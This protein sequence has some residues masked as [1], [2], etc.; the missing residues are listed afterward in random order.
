MLLPLPGQLGEMAD[1]SANDLRSRKQCLYYLPIAVKNAIELGRDDTFSMIMG[2][3]ASK[4]LSDGMVAMLFNFAASLDGEMRG[5]H[6]LDE[7]D[8]SLLFSYMI[9]TISDEMARFDGRSAQQGA[10]HGRSDARERMKELSGRLRSKE[11]PK[12]P[13]PGCKKGFSA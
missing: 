1:S 5:F 4:E 10:A 7:Q 12:A 6:T 9:S 11:M 13:G 8:L 3:R 2:L